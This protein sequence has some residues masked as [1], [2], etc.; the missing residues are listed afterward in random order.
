MSYLSYFLQFQMNYGRILLQYRFS[1]SLAP[2]FPTSFPIFS[3]SLYIHFFIL[4]NYTKLLHVWRDG[5]LVFSRAQS[6]IPNNKYILYDFF[7]DECAIRYMFQCNSKIM[8]FKKQFCVCLK[9]TKKKRLFVTDVTK[10]GNYWNCEVKVFNNIK[11]HA[12]LLKW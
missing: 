9:Q 2:F 3:V 7:F 4:K 6:L 12:S 1:E 10:L 5:F 11:P 8:F